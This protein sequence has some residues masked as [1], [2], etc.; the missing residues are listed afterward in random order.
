MNI[1]LSSD[2]I[3]NINEN[4]FYNIL[5]FKLQKCYKHK[6]SIPYPYCGVN[7]QIE[8]TYK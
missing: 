4:Q 3:C 7:T 6:K 1:C 5:A 8:K 2:K